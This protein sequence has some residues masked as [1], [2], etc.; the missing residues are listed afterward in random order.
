MA[1]DLNFVLDADTRKYTQKLEK[2]LQKT[3]RV[4]RSTKSVGKSWDN[5]GRS[6][7]GAIPGLSNFLGVAGAV[8]ATSAG[9]L[10]IWQLITAEI[11]KTKEEQGRATSVVQA[12]VSGGRGRSAEQISNLQQGIRELF[13]NI[14]TSISAEQLPELIAAADSAGGGQTD[15]QFL[16]TI[17][18]ALEIGGPAGPGTGIGFAS[19]LDK[20]R[21]LDIED[22]AAREIAR[23]A[24]FTGAKGPRRLRSIL[25]KLTDE[26]LSGAEAVDFLR[27]GDLDVF[28]GANANFVI[29][30]R[31]TLE[32]GL[33]IEQFREAAFEDPNLAASVER[34][35]VLNRIAVGRQEDTGVSGAAFRGA[36][37][38]EAFTEALGRS[39]GGPFAGLVNVLDDL[40]ILAPLG[41]GA[42]GTAGTA[43][44]PEGGRVDIAEILQQI[45]QNTRQ[46]PQFDHGGA[47]E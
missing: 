46:D 17:A 43:P 10:K 2:A 7:A 1:G 6:I 45:E 27:T 16:L 29:N 20:L 3:R 30:L 14:K 26:G 40:G 35:S 32:S 11:Q 12:L 33:N 42:A 38:T 41:L 21:A 4:G 31:K 47:N 19:A 24:A 9:I 13:S 28:E 15:K 23:A 5:T 37:R 36:R 18:Q 34:Q 44:R 22:T 25:G 39:F 8:A